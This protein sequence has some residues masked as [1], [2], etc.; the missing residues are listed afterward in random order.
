MFSLTPDRSLRDSRDTIQ[1]EEDPDS[2]QA[3]CVHDRGEGVNVKDRHQAERA[4]EAEGAC[5]GDGHAV[6]GKGVADG[7][8]GEGRTWGGES[9][10]PCF[11]PV[12]PV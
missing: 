6:C 5:N 9:I 12:G 4:E 7:A 3:C 2:L 8:I 10:M 1:K 11:G